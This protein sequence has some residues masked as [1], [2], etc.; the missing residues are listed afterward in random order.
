M[1]ATIGDAL[2]ETCKKSEYSWPD[3]PPPDEKCQ[4]LGC[5]INGINYKQSE[6]SPGRWQWVV[7]EEAEKRIRDEEAHRANLYWALRSRVLNDEEMAEVERYGSSLNIQ[8]M[9]SYSP[10]EKEMELNNALLQQF[11]LREIAKAANK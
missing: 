11:R 5:N 3:C 6:V 9:V 1:P 8:L 4:Y 2:P 10:H 7:N